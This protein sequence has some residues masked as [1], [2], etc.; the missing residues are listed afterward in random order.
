MKIAT[1]NINNVNRRLPNLLAWLARRE[2]R[3]RLPAGAEGAR[4]ASFRA[5]GAARRPA[6]ARSGAGR[7]PGTASPSWRAAPSRSLTRDASCPAIRTTTQSRYIEAAV[8]G[9][10]DRLASMRRTATRSPA[11]NSTTSSP[12]SS[13]SSRMRPSS[14]RPACRS[15]WPATTTSCRPTSTSI[16]PSPGT[17]TRCCSRESRAAFRRLLEQGWTDAIRTLHPGRADVHVLGLHA[18]P[19]AA[20]RRPAPRPSAAEPR[21]CA[22]RLASAGVD[23]EVRGKDGRQRPRAGLDRAARRPAS[24]PR[25]AHA[26]T[27]SRERPRKRPRQA[28]THASRSADA[29]PLLV[30]DGDSFAHRAYHALP[31]TI[32][33]A[34]ASGRRRDRRLRQFPAAVLREREA[35]RRAGRLG[36][37]RRADLSAQ[38]VSRP[39][40]AAASSTTS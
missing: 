26:K 5:D 29:R 32:L 8:N 25:R 28:T 13:G 24:E 10:L 9:V 40:R 7:R 30:V 12:G 36:H 14:T 18:E 6:T 16:R 15:C 22:T 33:R 37:A 1:F 4:I 38:G 27:A 11:R 35:A 21:R 2:A 19:L 23:R 3:R 34:A 31:K 39:T 20:R 17:T